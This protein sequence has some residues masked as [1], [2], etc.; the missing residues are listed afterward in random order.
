VLDADAIADMRRDSGMNHRQSLTK[1]AYAILGL[2]SAA[3]AG[4]IYEA[5]R[6][7]S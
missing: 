1:G 6:L 4:L 3:F 2:G 7:L 5:V